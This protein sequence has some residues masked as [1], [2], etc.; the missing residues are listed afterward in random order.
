MAI[1]VESSNSNTTASGT[2][3][4]ITKPTGLAVGDLLVAC[5]YSY[6][7]VG[8][9]DDI[10]T[11]T[12]W[13]L[14]QSSGGFPGADRHR[15]STFIKVADSSDVAASNFT[16]TTTNS[17]RIAGLLMRVSGISAIDPY[18]VGGSDDH[19][20]TANPA[21]VYA[22]TPATNNTL[23][24]TAIAGAT[25][26]VWAE[27]SAPVISGT[28]PTWTNRYDGDFEVYTAP[29]TATSQIT[30]LDVTVDSGA[31][32]STSWVSTITIIDGRTDAS[33]ENTLVTTT[34]TTFTQA[35][36]ADTITGN[37][38]FT[39]SSETFTQA[40]IGTSPTQWINGNKNTSTWTN[41][42]QS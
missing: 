34:S 1:V 40:G 42:Q 8:G 29:Y 17:V 28:N 2:S 16:F 39:T 38:F 18:S 35:G 32:G 22:I 25:N 31:S 7:T 20:D 15:T 5:I 21:F 3:L 26:E 24:I 33:A 27:F 12:N 41:E 10:N 6:N 9:A 4:V 19:E 30:S 23:L 13:E 37:T 36:T 14:T 11:P